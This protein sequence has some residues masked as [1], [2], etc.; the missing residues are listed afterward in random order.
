VIVPERWWVEE[1]RGHPRTLVALVVGL[2]LFA[3]GNQLLL[4]PGVALS[5]LAVGQLVVYWG[6]ETDASVDRR[7]V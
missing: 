3:T 4:W 1:A 6:D 2:G 5:S 7:A